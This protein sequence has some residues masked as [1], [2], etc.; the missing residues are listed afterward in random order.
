MKG[1]L[2]KWMVCMTAV[3]PVLG[4]AA[5]AAAETEAAALDVTGIV[6]AAMMLIFDMLLAW[7]ARTLLP[8]VG[9][10]LRERTTESQRRMLCELTEKLV[11]AAEQL[12]GAGKGAEKLQYVV[13]GL[14]KRGVSVDMDLIEAAVR[15]MNGK[16]LA[17]IGEELLEKTDQAV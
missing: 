6:I 13:D 14:K 15:E 4:R 8:A 2:R 7:A 12:L 10:W 3:L 11:C 9:S 16:A 1:T 5:L 17:K